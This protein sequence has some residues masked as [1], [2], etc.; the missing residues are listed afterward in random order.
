R[1][2]RDNSSSVV[3]PAAARAREAG[4]LVR[5]SS[6]VWSA[7]MARTLPHVPDPGHGFRRLPALLIHQSAPRLTAALRW[8]TVAGGRGRRGYMRWSAGPG[9]HAGWATKTAPQDGGPSNGDTV[10]HT[11]RTAPAGRPGTGGRLG[12]R[13]GGRTCRESGDR[14]HDQAGDREPQPAHRRLHVL[15]RGH[16]PAEGDQGQRLLHE[17]QLVPGRCRQEVRL[18]LLEVPGHAGCGQEAR[19]E[20]TRRE[21]TRGEETRREEAHGEDDDG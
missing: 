13:P 14:G 6:W 4:A 21:E 1:E 12:G 11:R 3:I 17:G 15:P 2:C 7:S 18:G 10:D 19:R 5:G 20:E 9:Q 16:D 8:S